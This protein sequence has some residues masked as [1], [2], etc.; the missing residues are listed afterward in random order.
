MVLGEEHAALGVR[1]TG[2]EVE[3]LACKGGAGG[4]AQHKRS[5]VVMESLNLK[6]PPASYGNQERP[7]GGIS[8]RGIEENTYTS[9][10]SPLC[11]NPQTQGC[12]SLR[13]GLDEKDRGVEVV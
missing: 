2:L 5:D 10:S 1:H 9:Q 11:P 3:H 12:L 7:R 8:K 13:D 4:G 6:T